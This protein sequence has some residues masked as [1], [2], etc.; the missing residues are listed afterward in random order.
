MSQENVEIVRNAFHTLRA[1]ETERAPT[2]EAKTL[3]TA[4]KRICE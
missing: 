3:Y 1:A 2:A 4:A